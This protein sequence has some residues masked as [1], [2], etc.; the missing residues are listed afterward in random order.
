MVFFASVLGF[1]LPVTAVQLL[2]INLVTDGLP[3]VAVS[4][5][6]PSREV[7]Q[8]PPRD[9]LEPLLPGKTIAELVAMGFAIGLGSLAIFALSVPKGLVVA[10]TM[11]FTGIVLGEFVQ[12]F[13]IRKQYATGVFENFWLLLSVGAAIIL[14][15]LLLYTPIAQ[16]FHVVP[17]GQNDWLILGAL[18]AALVILGSVFRH[19]FRATKDI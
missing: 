18:L 12:L 3:A 5:D 15:L 6:P 1:P 13:M 9:P 4:V 8:R 14:Q 19:F 7:M 2:W 10:Q 16:Y 17:L 11:A